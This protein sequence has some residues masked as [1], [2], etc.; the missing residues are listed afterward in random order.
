MVSAPIHLRQQLCSVLQVLLPWSV[1]APSTLRRPVVGDEVVPGRHRYSSSDLSCV[2]SLLSSATSSR[3]DETRRIQP[4]LSRTTKTLQVPASITLLSLLIRSGVDSNI[5]W[6]VCS[7]IFVTMCRSTHLYDRFVH[8]MHALDI[9]DTDSYLRGEFP[10]IASVPLPPHTKHSLCCLVS[11]SS[12]VLHC[13]AEISSTCRC[14]SSRRDTPSRI[15]L[16]GE[17]SSPFLQSSVQRQQRQGFTEIPK[18]PG[19]G[20]MILPITKVHVTRKQH[21]DFS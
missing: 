18:A 3:I 20:H 6:A 13:T 17:V 21:G 5:T 16:R 9:E 19:C 7:R 14:I 4:F 8:D 1:R 10:S 2:R 11:A 15:I 12:L